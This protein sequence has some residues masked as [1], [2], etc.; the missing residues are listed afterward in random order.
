MIKL[1]YIFSHFV[2][3]HE[4]YAYSWI[5]CDTTCYQCTCVELPELFGFNGINYIWPV[6]ASQTRMHTVLPARQNTYY[7]DN[8]I[9]AIVI[10]FIS[11]RFFGNTWRLRDKNAFSRSQ[12][13]TKA[14]V[15][16]SRDGE[17]ERKK[18]RLKY[19]ENVKMVYIRE[20]NVFETFT[21]HSQYAST[22]TVTR[23]LTVPI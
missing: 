9:C 6:L 8:L 3:I 12:S 14:N 1:E 5:S 17:T 22:S 13:P 2:T 19:L 7:L 18:H 16:A 21:Y 23:Q 11:L 10:I 15:V 20:I 4:A